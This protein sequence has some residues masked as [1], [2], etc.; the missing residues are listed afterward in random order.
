M[1]FTMTVPTCPRSAFAMEPLPVGAVEI[2]P[3]VPI[4]HEELAIPKPIVNGI[5]FEDGFLIAD[6]VG[7]ALHLIVPRETAVQGCD[8]FTVLHGSL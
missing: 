2:R 1:S 5:F 6:A 7:I 3:A 4:I 8:F